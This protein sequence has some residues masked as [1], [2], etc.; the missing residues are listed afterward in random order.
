MN[1]TSIGTE[2]RAGTGVPGLDDILG[3]GLPRNRLYLVD[4]NPGVGKTT[5]ALRFLLHGAQNG[6]RCLYIT[7]SETQTELD[8]V[9]RSHG[10]TLDGIHIIELSAVE[11]SLAGKAQNTMFQSAEVELTHLG[12]LV[13]DEVDRQRPQRVVFDS[14]SELRLLAQNS[15]RYRRQILAFKTRLAALN[16]TVLLLDDRSAVGADVQ[17]H[18]IVHGVISMEIAPLKYGVF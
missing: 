5:L 3:G 12:K 2:E 4:G 16:A 10:W 15:L 9:A 14:L 1:A 18:S 17:V 7:L 6:E 8:A 11:K 13:L